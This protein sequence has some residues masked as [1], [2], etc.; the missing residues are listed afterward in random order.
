M[1]AE[2]GRT[3]ASRR[4]GSKPCNAENPRSA[5]ARTPLDPGQ[6]AQGLIP[7]RL[8]IPASGEIVM[9]AS[10]VVPAEALPWLAAVLCFFGVFIVAV[11]GTHVWT[12]LPAKTPAPK[13]RD[14]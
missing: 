9:P 2:P 14:Q 4:T 5:R 12:L 1:P 10:P 8:A 11:G 13:S 6:G 3:L 7:A